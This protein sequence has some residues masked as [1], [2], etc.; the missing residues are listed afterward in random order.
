MGEKTELNDQGYLV[1]KDS[2]KLVH[3]WKAAKKYGHEKIDGKEIPDAIL[4]E[5]D[6]EDLG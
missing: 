5:L 4:I 1:F 2:G 6:K 3:R